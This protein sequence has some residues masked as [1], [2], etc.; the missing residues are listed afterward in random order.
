MFELFSTLLR[1]FQANSAKGSNGDSPTGSIDRTVR[2]AEA[3]LK[4]AR[5]DLAGLIRQQRIEQTGLSLL[6]RRQSA[7]EDRVRQAMASGSIDLATDGAR[8]I[9]D[10]ENQASVRMEALARLDEKVARLRHAMAVAQRQIADPRQG[11][12]NASPADAGPPVLPI[13]DSSA[14]SR[15]EST[16]VLVRA[17]D[18]LVRLET[19]PAP[20]TQYLSP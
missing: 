6:R 5:R 2:A 12:A 15:L 20:T 18:V 8:A 1:D 4:D 14:R 11:S 13:P 10:I 16:A 7:L 17:E 3:R 9:A 19:T